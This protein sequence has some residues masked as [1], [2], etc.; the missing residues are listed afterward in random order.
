MALV[1]LRELLADAQKK[2]YAVGAFNIVN[3]ESAQAL[4]AAAEQEKSPFILQITQ[5]TIGMPDK[6]EYTHV[7]ELLAVV[8]VLAQRTSVPMAIHLDHG[9]SF[10]MCKMAIEKGFTSVMRDGSLDEKGKKVNTLDV[11][12]KKTKEAVE[13]AHAQNPLVTVEGELGTLGDITPDMTAAQR[14]KKLTQPSQVKKFCEKSGCDAL[15]IAFGTKHGPYKGKPILELSVIAACRKVTDVPLVMHGGSGVPPEAVKEAVKLGIAKINIDTQIR[16]AFEHAVREAITAKTN[17]YL[18]AVEDD[19]ESGE[20]LDPPKFDIRKILGPGRDAMTQAIAN[21]M[22]LF[23][24]SG[25][26]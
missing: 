20:L 21:K 22:K 11:N 13:L 5:T 16:M 26:A 25:K 1:S 14:K 12:I 24:S 15:A 9:R 7:D 19:I 10:E 18:A 3:M 8:N 23:G 4:V 17:A 2:K 6:V